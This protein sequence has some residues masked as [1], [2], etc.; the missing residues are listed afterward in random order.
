MNTKTLVNGNTMVWFSREKKFKIISKS[1]PLI[2]TLIE[3]NLLEKQYSKILVEEIRKAGLD[4]MHGILLEL[5]EMFQTQMDSMETRNLD[6]VFNEFNSIFHTNYKYQKSSNGL[7]SITLTHFGIYQEF[8]KDYFGSFILKLFACKIDIIK[9]EE[10]NH[11][12]QGLTEFI[13]K[14]APEE[15]KL[16]LETKKDMKFPWV[17]NIVY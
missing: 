13:L 14:F 4:D 2:D 10:E 11:E 15:M 16:Y 17:I 3:A 8:V 6:E 12:F 1:E 7:I 9:S 5:D